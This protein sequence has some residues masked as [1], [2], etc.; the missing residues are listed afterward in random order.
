[1][2]SYVELPIGIGLLPCDTLIED[3]ITGKKSVIGIIGTIR[4]T[5]FPCKYPSINLLVSLTSGNGSYPCSLEVVSES[6]NEVVFSGQG[7]LKFNDP[8]QVVD[9][10]FVLQR[11]QF[12][13]A[14]TYWI[15][16]MVDGEPLMMRPIHVKLL[17]PPED[18]IRPE[19]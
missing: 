18:S 1:M 19:L 14:D 4:V 3:K 16:F 9:L 11:L 2:S 10:V 17:E 8:T 5:K 15:K 6:K 13:Y 7:T 12:N